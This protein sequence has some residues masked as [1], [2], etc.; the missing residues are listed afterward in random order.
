[1]LTVLVEVACPLGRPGRV[2]VVYDTARV[3]RFAERG[4]ITIVREHSPVPD[5]TVN[6]P[7]VPESEPIFSFDFESPG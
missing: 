5:W 6:E 1:M 4:L 7:P 3:R 2:A